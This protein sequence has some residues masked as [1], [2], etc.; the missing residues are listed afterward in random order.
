M[1]FLY[2]RLVIGLS[3]SLFHSPWRLR[4]TDRTRVGVVHVDSLRS[5]IYMYASAVSRIHSQ[6]PLMTTKTSHRHDLIV[7]RATRLKSTYS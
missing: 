7:A 4:Y 6:S 1:I 5:S 3:L 2:I